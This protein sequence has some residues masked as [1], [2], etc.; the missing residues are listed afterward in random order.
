MAPTLAMHVLCVDGEMNLYKSKC[1]AAMNLVM[2]MLDCLEANLSSW[3]LLFVQMTCSVLAGV[4]NEVLLKG[5]DSAKRGVTTNLQPLGSFD[6]FWFP[7]FLKWLQI[8]VVLF[9]LFCQ[10]NTCFKLRNAFMY[11]QSILVNLLVLFYEGVQEAISAQNLEAIASWQVLGIIGIMSS[12][13]LVTGFFL[14]HLDSVLKAV[15]S[16]LEAEH[17]KFGPCWD[18]FDIYS[19]VFLPQKKHMTPYKKKSADSF[20]I[21]IFFPNSLRKKVFEHIPKWQKNLPFLAVLRWSSPCCWASYY[22]ARP[23]GSRAS[24]RASWWG[25]GWRST[26]DRCLPG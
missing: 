3:F 7:T 25:W 18:H 2:C 1:Q 8:L 11:I 10:Q 20:I 16:A 14:K 4:Y 12:V 23:W 13:G 26:R 19:H 5:Q 17:L 21:V 24:S 15:A 22:S 6:N 9:G